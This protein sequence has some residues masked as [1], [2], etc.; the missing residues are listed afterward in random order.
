M[1]KLKTKE[2]I[3]ESFKKGTLYYKHYK[4]LELIFRQHFFQLGVIF[5][6]E[7]G[8]ADIYS[9][10]INQGLFTSITNENHISKEVI[11]YKE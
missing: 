11:F 4:V 7:K 3:E 6:D 10:A 1:I 5:I 2:E 9:D 8:W